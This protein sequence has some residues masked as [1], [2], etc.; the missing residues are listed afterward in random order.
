MENEKQGIQ[1]V[2]IKMVDDAFLDLGERVTGTK[3]AF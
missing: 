3:K 2:K 1:L